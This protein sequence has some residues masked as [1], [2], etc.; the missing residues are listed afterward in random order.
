MEPFRTAGQVFEAV[1]KNPALTKFIPLAGDLYQ[2]YVEL[3]NPT[4]PRLG[5][6]VLNAAVVGGGGALAS[7]GTAGIDQYLAIPDIIGTV[8]EGVGADP[9]PDY[10]RAAALNIEH[11]LREAAYKLGG[12]GEAAGL[13][14]LTGTIPQEDAKLK[15][16]REKYNYGPGATGVN[17]TFGKPMT[18]MLP[19]R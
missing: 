16:L 1:R 6:R 7:T 15:A 17:S 11:Y 9:N 19:V 14:Y 10:D 12:M 2:G 18:L 13:P 8:A 3:T 4:E 5:Q